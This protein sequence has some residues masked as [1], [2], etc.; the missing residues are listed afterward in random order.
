MPLVQ[1]VRTIQSNYSS[2][3][4]VQL[5][6]SDQVMNNNDTTINDN[7][8]YCIFIVETFTTQYSP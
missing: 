6:Y 1:T 7:Y 4:S 2:I 8:R 5:S 3:R